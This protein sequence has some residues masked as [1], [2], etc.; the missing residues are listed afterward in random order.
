[1]KHFTT[2]QAA[3]DWVEN[4]LQSM[5]WTEKDLEAL[6][7]VVEL[8]GEWIKVKEYHDNQYP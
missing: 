8:A 1:M 6:Q 4:L 3:I 7:R 2:D 5:E